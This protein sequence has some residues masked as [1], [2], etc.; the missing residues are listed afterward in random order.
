MTGNSSKAALVLQPRDRTLFSALG[1]MRVV[2][3]QQAARAAGFTSRT[4]A[5]AR[6]LALSRAGLLVR[7]FVGSVGGG[8]RSLYT[9]T[10]QGAELVGAQK[11]INRKSGEQVS[12]DA[13]IEHQLHVNQVYL[14]ATQP[15]HENSTMH[16]SSWRVFYQPIS[17][18]IAL[19]PD[20]YLELQTGGDIRP[21]FLEVDLGTESQTVWGEKVRQYVQLAVSGDF[22]R[23]FGRGKFRVLV[24]APSE[25]RLRSIQKT[26]LQR[27]D[28]I[29]WLT[30]FEAINRDG[31]CAAVWLRPSGEQ[32]Q[33]LI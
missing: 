28:K 11:G 10:Q 16:V 33:S 6:L 17:K 13:F 5:N 25:A 27:T 9:L 21:A 15:R 30:T 20:G 7:F 8:R 1:I 26:V 32:K 2:D 23:Q 19:T 18:A 22:Q 29:F 24:I 4:R 14:A 12:G 31:F 3:R